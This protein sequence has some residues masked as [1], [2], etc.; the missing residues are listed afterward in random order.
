MELLNAQDG[1]FQRFSRLAVFRVLRVVV[2]GGG[3]GYV[4]D[5]C[6]DCVGGV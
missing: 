1:P 3:G 4:W 5:D 6:V 2:R